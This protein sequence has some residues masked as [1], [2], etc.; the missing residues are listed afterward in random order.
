M[1]AIG[2][3]YYTVYI[4]LLAQFLVVVYFFFPETKGHSL[5]QIA[6]IFEGNIMTGRVKKSSDLEG[7][8]KKPVMA[9]EHVEYIS[10]EGK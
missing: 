7:L 10:A 6:D 3:K 5:E 1:D 8:D 9:E 2:W 4:A